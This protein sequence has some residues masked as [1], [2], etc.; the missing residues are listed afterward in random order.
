MDLKDNDGLTA[1]RWAEK[2]GHKE[3]IQLL[4]EAGAKK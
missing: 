3:I 1:L 2:G 4:R